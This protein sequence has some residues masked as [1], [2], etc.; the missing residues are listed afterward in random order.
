MNRSARAIHCSSRDGDPPG[1]TATAGGSET[2]VPW[3][4]TSRESASE[5]GGAAAV[6][7]MNQEKGPGTGTVN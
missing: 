3:R 6:V 7:V 1:T 5:S 2:G 4:G